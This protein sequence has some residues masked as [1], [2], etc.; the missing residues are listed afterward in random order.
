MRAEVLCLLDFLHLCCSDVMQI[1]MMNASSVLILTTSRQRLYSVS[2]WE[3]PWR[4]WAR[5]RVNAT[6][7]ILCN[8]PG[9]PFWTCEKTHKL[10]VWQQASSSRIRA[11]GTVVF[12]MRQSILSQAFSSVSSWPPQGKD[13][14]NTRQRLLLAQAFSLNHP[15]V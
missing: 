8:N 1:T 7:C 15:S 3:R 9:I 13:Y 6:R 10:R 12:E 5:Q 11:D 14:F 4:H 2:S